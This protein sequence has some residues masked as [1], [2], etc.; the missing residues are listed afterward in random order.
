MPKRP[1][2]LWI[3][4]VGLFMALM[5]VSAG[6]TSLLPGRGDDTDEEARLKELLTVPEPP[7]LLREAAI[8]HGLRPIQVD[9]VALVY[10][11]GDSGGAADPSFFR[12]QLVDELKRDDI[13]S[14]NL[15]LEQPDTA[16]VRIR[17]IIPPG[18]QR[19]D[20]VDIR[21]L[22]PAGSKVAD[23][24]GGKMLKS[25]L[26]HQQRIK[27][28][29]RK[30]DVMVVGQGTVLTRA[31]FEPG[32]DEALRVE[33]T[34]LGGG[35][36]QMSR[37]LGLVLRPEYEHAKLSAELAAAVNRRFFFFD[38]TSRRGIARALEDDFIE[39]DLHPR[40]RENIY[41]LMAVIRS[42]KVN[43]N[44]AESQARLED[45]SER[46]S[47]PATAA[48]AALQLEAIGENAIPTLLSGIESSNP[49]LR[50]YAAEALAYLDRPEAVEPL[51]EAARSEAAF[52]HD[53]LLALQQMPRF[54][55]VS[56]LKRLMDEASLETRYG[57]FVALRSRDD[58]RS[59]L[60]GRRLGELDLFQIDSTAPPAVV[61]SLREN[62][63]VVLFGDVP[64]FDLSEVINTN[65]VMLVADSTEPGQIRVSRFAPDQED[66]RAMAGPTVVS[67]V[68]AISNVG[69]KYGDVVNVLRMSK[70]KQILDCQL[71]FDPLPRP[72]RTYHR[73]QDEETEEADE[74]ET[75]VVAREE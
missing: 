58:A 48:D 41:R 69:A 56:A 35:T 1:P 75:E 5:S 59:H 51:E 37:K 9:G 29:V 55:A 26:R 25:R 67:V 49:E 60:I 31:D 40:Y 8:P 34:I 61:I 16:L 32:N 39:I 71:A 12:D 63:E 70:E 62:A 54:E 43:G 15:V 46:L 42:I 28:Q 6:C 13:P 45:L 24:H 23:L 36:V 11:L 20:L 73:E 74:F 3:T 47:S 19:R 68:A 65:G 57:A 17:A 50:F 4:F 33:G 66:K 2:F 72:L 21:V 52:R 53:A 38:G 30:S 14:P 44:A 64:A 7:E 22:S 27:G 18:A 10:E